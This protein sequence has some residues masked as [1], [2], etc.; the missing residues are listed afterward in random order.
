MRSNVVTCEI[1]FFK[2]LKKVLCRCVLLQKEV[3]RLNPNFT[4]ENMR[5]LNPHWDPNHL[6]RI[7]SVL[8]RAASSEKRRDNCSI[9]DC[10]LIFHKEGINSK[11][12]P[13]STWWTPPGVRPQRALQTIYALLNKTA[14]H[15]FCDMMGSTSETE[16]QVVF[17]GALTR[18][19]IRLPQHER[20][21]ETDGVLQYAPYGL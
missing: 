12:G 20:Y 9:C 16:Y 8:R 21:Q 4:L 14:S 10:C 2:N 11:P 3:F 5:K 6:D 7:T 1:I 15:G 17:Q 18:F 19:Q 13:K